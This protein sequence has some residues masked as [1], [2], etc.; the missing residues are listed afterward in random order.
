[1]AKQQPICT[2]TVADSTW[3]F[4][5]CFFFHHV[6]GGEFRLEGGW[7]FGAFEHHFLKST[8]W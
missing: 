4:L 3:N 1:M 6:R 5:G 7:F 2:A 8:L